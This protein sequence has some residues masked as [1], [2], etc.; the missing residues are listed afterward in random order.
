MPPKGVFGRTQKCGEIESVQGGCTGISADILP[1]L[2]DDKLY[3]MLK[4]PE[5]TYL[6]ECPSLRKRVYENM[7]MFL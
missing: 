6:K 1:D 4:D 7:E 2:L 5:A 3:E